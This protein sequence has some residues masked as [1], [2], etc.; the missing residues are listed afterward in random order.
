MDSASLP[1]V[2]LATSTG[3]PWWCSSCLQKKNKPNVKARSTTQEEF[4]DN[5]KILSSKAAQQLS[6]KGLEPLFCYDNNRIQKGAEWGRMG[7]TR[8]QKVEIPTH[9]PDFNKPIEHVFNQ[10]KEKLCE[11]IYDSHEVLTPELLQQWVVLIF[12]GISADSIARDVSSLEQTYLAVSADKGQLISDGY[13][14]IVQGTGG[15]YPKER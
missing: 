7:I 12:Q 9:S 14:Q 13:S 4:E 5:M 6:T 3:A 1:L 15:D 8:Q 11:Y 2:V 10:I